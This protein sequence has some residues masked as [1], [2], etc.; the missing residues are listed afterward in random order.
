MATSAISLKDL[1]NDRLISVETV[2]DEPDDLDAVIRLLETA[3]QEVVRTLPSKPTNEM[4][5]DVEEAVWETISD[6]KDVMSSMHESRPLH[7]SVYDLFEGKKP[8]ADL[9]HQKTKNI[10]FKT[11]VN[12]NPDLAEI[13]VSWWFQRP[14]QKI[15][16]TAPYTGTIEDYVI[17]LVAMSIKNAEKPKNDCVMVKSCLDN[18]FAGEYVG[19]LPDTDWH[20]DPLTG[21]KLSEWGETKR[22]EQLKS[23][24]RV[25]AILKTA[26][27]GLVPIYI[28]KT[29]GIDPQTKPSRVLELPPYILEGLQPLPKGRD[30]K[31]DSF[32]QGR[33]GGDVVY[34]D[35]NDVKTLEKPQKGVSKAYKTLRAT[36][37]KA[38]PLNVLKNGENGVF[39]S[40]ND[41]SEKSLANIYSIAYNFSEFSNRRQ[42][43]RQ[44]TKHEGTGG[45]RRDVIAEM[46]AHKDE[47]GGSYAL[48]KRIN[49]LAWI[50]PVVPYWFR[51][52]E[53]SSKLKGRLES[54]VETNDK[55]NADLLQQYAD[56]FNVRPYDIETLHDLLVPKARPDTPISLEGFREFAEVELDYFQN[57]LVGAP[58]GYGK[59]YT[60]Q[61]KKTSQG[62]YLK[63]IVL[64]REVELKKQFYQKALGLGRKVCI[65]H[66]NDVRTELKETIDFTADTFI[67]TY[68]KFVRHYGQTEDIKKII[69]LVDCII[70]D[71]A[72]NIDFEKASAILESRKPFTLLSANNIE[73][74]LPSELLQAISQEHRYSFRKLERPKLTIVCRNP[75]RVNHCRNRMPGDLILVSSRADALFKAPRSARKGLVQDHAEEL[76]DFDID[77]IQ[78]M[79]ERG[80]KVTMTS[81]GNAGINIMV[82]RLVELGVLLTTAKAGYSLIDNFT[83]AQFVGRLRK[84]VSR[85]HL[86]VGRSICSFNAMLLKEAVFHAQFVSVKKF[87]GLHNIHKL[88]MIFADLSRSFELEFVDGET[89]VEPKYSRN[90]LTDEQKIVTT[91]LGIIDLPHFE[92]KKKVN[93]EK[94]I[95]DKFK[96]SHWSTIAQTFDTHSNV[97]LDTCVIKPAP[98]KKRKWSF[99]ARQLLEYLRDNVDGMLTHEGQVPPNPYTKI[100]SARANDID[101]PARQW[102]EALIEKCGGG[103]TSD[104]YRG[105]YSNA[106]HTVL[107][108][109]I[110]HVYYICKVRGF[111]REYRDEI[112]QALRDDPTLT[113]KELEIIADKIPHVDIF[114]DVPYYKGLCEEYVSMFDPSTYM[115]A[116]GEY[117]LSPKPQKQNLLNF[118]MFQCIKYMDT[119]RGRE[120]KK[121]YKDI[122]EFLERRGVK[123]NPR[124][125]Y[126]LET[127]PDAFIRS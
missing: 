94:D 38:S 104:R 54:W 12:P 96:V 63:N 36:I 4:S 16:G 14:G 31:A 108:K 99:T 62:R 113:N 103:G 43:T 126:G 30:F 116:Y 2:S 28:L 118:L 86:T 57:N 47:D 48:G 40:E 58:M 115:N 32:S 93:V 88:A 85:L 21:E 1:S 44:K 75:K 79:L 34:L 37:F 68:D 125:M 77:T 27:G 72:Q 20:K 78:Q 46:L 121:D 107:K 87:K 105:R 71:E 42:N 81:L 25:V 110:D 64:V 119:K 73:A 49:A 117:I 120:L 112:L 39:A 122:F 83:V 76:G 23:D 52:L 67:M 29:T 59:S 10:D 9:I 50:S 51:G 6:E 82:D 102:A 18:K 95:F 3:V 11:S 26:G 101:V 24:G 69:Q 100:L 22:L 98:D 111:P 65:V 7:Q 114:S 13:K 124:L 41:D 92:F 123:R 35:G 90:K 80:E 15:K 45:G 97:N 70:C 56:K 5:E 19:Y 91:I 84:G 33:Y 61:K 55:T 74:M 17:F 60:P 53:I 89:P 66:T 106:P 8:P 109:K 127:V